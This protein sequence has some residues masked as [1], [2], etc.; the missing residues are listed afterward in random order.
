MDI[1]DGKIAVSDW[2]D[3]EVLEFS[4][5]S[6]ELVG[7]KNNTRR[8]M[9][10]ATKNNY[11][12]S[13]EWATVQVFEY[14]EV[15]G[16]D[17]DLNTY[18]LNYPYVENG[19]SYTMTLDVT[20]NG[21]QTLVINESY[22]TNSEFSPSFL[23]N[24]NPGETESVNITYTANSINASGSYRIY[25]NDSDEPEILCETN[26]NI[27]GANIGD[28]APDFE[29]NIV[30]NG[31]GTFRLSDYLG[32]IVVLAFFSPM[33]PVCSPELSDF[34]TAIWQEYQNEDVI[35]VGIIN[36]SNQGQLNNFVAENS[37]T[38][39][40]IFDP[41]SPGGVQGGNTYDLYYMP[42]DGSP[43]PRGNYWIC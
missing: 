41:G 20:N 25:S 33:W 32:Q 28:Q 8:T 40:I 35:V 36:T 13:A 42:N 14:G 18:E 26:G 4:N 34:E 29:L 17:I 31:E 7:Y 6:L 22:T 30:A 37:I 16:P 24:I 21:N 43:Y 12:Y 39:P 38:F 2:D 9:A 15:E 5:D 27:N 19:S 11:I 23:G 1:F 3:V 10:I